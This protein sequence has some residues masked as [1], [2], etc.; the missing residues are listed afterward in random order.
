MTEARTVA[1]TW[2]RTHFGQ[3][4]REVV[5]T[6]EHFIVERDGMP[7]VVILSVPEYERLQRQAAWSRFYELSRQAGL[8]AEEEGLTEE[9]IQAEIA[10]IKRQVYTE[11]Y[12]CG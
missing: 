6:K 2:A 4:M 3:L 1:A 7:T 11:R 5:R 9:E 10:A 12:G 8:E